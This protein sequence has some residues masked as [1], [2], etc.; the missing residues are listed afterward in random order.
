MKT[1]N[2][3]SEVQSN[4][5]ALKLLGLWPKGDETYKRN[6]YTLYASFCFFVLNCGHNF[7]QT[8]NI[9]FIL[10]D[11]EAFTS[12][13][14]VT[15][16]CVGTI[17]KCYGLIQNMENL[18]QLFVTI[19]GEIFQPKGE[20]QQKLVEPSVKFWSRIY[21]LFRITCYFTAFFWSTY[22][23]LD[24]SFRVRRLPFL[25]WYPY[26][27]KIS[28]FYEFTYMYQVVSIWYIVAASLNIDCLIAALNMFIG[29]QCDILCDDL[30]NL[31]ATNGK[32][33]KEKLVRCVIHHKAILSLAEKSNKFYNWIVLFQFFTSAVSLGFSMFQL[34]IVVPLSSEFY[35]FICYATSMIVEIFIYCWFGNEVEIKS[36]IIPYAAFQS[37]WVGLPTEIQ[38]ILITFT[39]R[40]QRPIKMSAL[41]LFYLSLD[42]FKSILRTSWSY[43]TVLHQANST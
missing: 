25:S 39:L 21:L 11:L 18:K 19:T 37:T 13:I 4:I 3:K 22:P 9:Y 26:N 32:E 34:T 14:F 15:L 35:S 20:K 10:D 6:S 36:S 1:F 28:P 27:V 42:T 23:I 5:L 40:T 38:K 41:N 30:R 12:S 33:L 8:V 31:V 2:W 43:F 24:K 29:A 17:L 7:F 16:S